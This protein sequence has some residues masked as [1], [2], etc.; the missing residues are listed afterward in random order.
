MNHKAYKLWFA[1]GLGSV[2]DPKI[3]K[4]LSNQNLELGG[5]YNCGSGI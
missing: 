2:L 3:N 1:E 5:S 4:H